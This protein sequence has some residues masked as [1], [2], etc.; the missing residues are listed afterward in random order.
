MSL[1]KTEDCEKPTWHPVPHQM[2]ILWHGDRIQPSLDVTSGVSSH[3]LII[4]HQPYLTWNTK[5]DHP[6]RASGS[7]PAWLSCGKAVGNTR[8]LGA[9]M[10]GEW[11]AMQ[12]VHWDEMGS[13]PTGW[14]EETLRFN[15]KFS[16]VAVDFWEIRHLGNIP[17]RL[18]VLKGK[19]KMKQ[20]NTEV[21]ALVEGILVDR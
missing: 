14:A 8:S 6:Q 10:C 18:M 19:R 4:V 13:P 3:S 17:L 11:A 12:A 15:I 7:Q 21:L 20:R 16:A 5:Q 9:D 2:E 1:C